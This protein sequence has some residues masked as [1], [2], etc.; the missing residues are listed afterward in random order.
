MAGEHIAERAIIDDG[1]PGLVSLDDVT[2]AVEI[3]PLAFYLLQAAWLPF[4]HRFSPWLAAFKLGAV[5]NAVAELARAL[6]HMSGGLDKHAPDL[7]RRLH[8]VELRNPLPMLT[9]YCRAD[10]QV[11]CHVI[12]ALV[13]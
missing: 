4:D 5:R 12:T 2:R 7:A 8:G 11:G 13:L 10:L 6:P 9:P 3:T 1:G